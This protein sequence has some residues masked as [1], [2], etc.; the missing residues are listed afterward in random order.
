[1]Q[2]ENSQQTTLVPATPFFR[3]FMAQEGIEIEEGESVTEYILRC[4]FP[5]SIHYKGER[6]DN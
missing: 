4:G 5:H 6:R 1:M 2:T 3:A